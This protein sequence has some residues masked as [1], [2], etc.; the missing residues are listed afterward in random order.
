MKA[1][2]A[3]TA[4]IEQASVVA[5]I[6]AQ[7]SATVGQGGPSNLQRFKAHHPPT[8][9]GEGDPMETDHWFR[10]VGK[11]L[12]AMEITFDATRIR[13]TASHLEGES[14]VWWDWVKASRNLEAMMWEEFRKLFMGKYFPAFERHAKAREF[15]EL[16]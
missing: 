12:E 10:K 5:T 9:K 7:A 3:T 15:L 6:I 2:S 1:I 8:I 13:L 14:Q 11:I 4:T 16:K